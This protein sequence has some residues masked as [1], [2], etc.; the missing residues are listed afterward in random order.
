LAAQPY[1]LS[2]ARADS[3]DP[4]TVAALHTL[5]A[6]ANASQRKVLWLSVTEDR[7]TTAHAAE[8]ADIITTI[9]HA[10][11][12]I[13][14]QLWSLPPNAIVVIDNPAAADPGQLAAITGYI[15]AT[16]ARAIILDPADGQFGPSTSALRLLA[17]TVPWTTTLTAG[18]TALEDHRGAPTP[19]IT[20]ADRLGRTR[21]N[22]PWC[23]L[24]TRYDTAARAIRSAHRL[25]LTLSWHDRSHSRDEPNRS[26]E[27]GI[28]D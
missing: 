11:E 23:Q 13:A 18:D 5:R 21:L 20:L 2:Y 22:E 19:A 17:R 3:T 14:E 9:D 6:A 8:L 27:A 10:H 15:T 24:L 7:G 1:R 12:E 4:D 28:D 25:H 26:L 16:D